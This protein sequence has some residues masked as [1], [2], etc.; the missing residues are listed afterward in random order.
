[1]SKNTPRNIE[2]FN[3]ISLYILIKLYE[4]FPN[5]IDINPEAMGLEAQ[6]DE[7]DWD[8]VWDLMEMSTN[9]VSWLKQENFISIE[10]STIGPFTYTGVRLTLKGLTLLGYFPENEMGNMESSFFSKAKDIFAKATEQ[11]ATDVINSLF[12][13]ALRYLPNLIG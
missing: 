9:T 1:M 3:R 13:T 10:G 4:S 6:P 8:K 2:V 5:P 7:E 12:S 11:S